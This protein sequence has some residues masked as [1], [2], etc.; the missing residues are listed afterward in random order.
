MSAAT[1]TAIALANPVW[2][3]AWARLD[4]DLREAL[5]NAGL[6]ESLTWGSM[7]AEDDDLDGQA[8]ELLQAFGLLPSEEEERATRIRQCLDLQRAARVPQRSWISQMAN[9][10]GCQVSLDLEQA[11]KRRKL[12]ERETTHTRL[13]LAASSGAPTEWRGKTYRRLEAADDPN[14]R[15]KAEKTERLKWGTEVVRLLVEAQL[16][17]GLEVEQKGYQTNGAEAFRCLRGL[18]APTLRKRVSDWRPCRRWLLSRWGAPYPKEPE[19]VHPFFKVRRDEG[20]PEPA[21]SLIHISEPTR[22]Y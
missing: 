15:A 3:S 8:A 10:P 11:E 2:L 6:A 17:F 9:M 20:Q 13:A 16:P 18:R 19:H 12:V 14:A 5:S 4:A 1:L 21:L 7:F 22:P